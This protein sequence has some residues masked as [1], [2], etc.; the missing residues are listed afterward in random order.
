MGSAAVAGSS[1][2]GSPRRGGVAVGTA[3]LPGEGLE[4]GGGVVVL[5]VTQLEPEVAE[6]VLEDSVGA[7]IEGREGRRVTA[8]AD[9]DAVRSPQLLG[10]VSLLPG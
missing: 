4:A 8:S 10:Q 2:R 1:C 5:P 9:P 7:V 3:A 6:A